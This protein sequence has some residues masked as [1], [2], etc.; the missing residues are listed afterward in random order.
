MSAWTASAASWQCASCSS[1]NWANK[2]SCR[3]CSNRKSYAQAIKLGPKKPT[4]AKPAP[5]TTPPPSDAPPQTTAPQTTAASPTAALAAIKLKLTALQAAK[6]ASEAAE[7]PTT[8]IDLQITEMTRQLHASKPAGAQL[9]GLKSAIAR[10][11]KRLAKAIHDKEDAQAR[12][13]L[14]SDISAKLHADMV[15]LEATMTTAVPP[16]GLHPGVA[17]QL[18]EAISSLRSGAVIQQ[19]AMAAFLEKLIFP[20]TMPP[21]TAPNEMNTN[22]Q[23]ST[24]GK[25][26]VDLSEVSDLSEMEEDTHATPWWDGFT[27]VGPTS[28][29]SRPWDDAHRRRQRQ[30]TMVETPQLALVA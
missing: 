19:E 9:D 24:P 23:P 15:T 13:K 20:T 25:P 6:L 14:E 5:P 1:H 10:A 21:T 11:D 2:H 18:S 29:P 8:A 22:G 28:S 16:N 12:I 30:K 7:L 3:G 4:A 27:P 26:S 17:A